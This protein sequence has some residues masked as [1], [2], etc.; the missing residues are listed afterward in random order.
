M[1]LL[2]YEMA[3]NSEIQSKLSKELWECYPTDELN[4][5]DMNKS[6]Y[7]DAVVNET[8]RKHTTVGRI[9]RKTLA[10]YDFGDF[11]VKKGQTIGIS[12]HNLHNDPALF[13]EPQ[14]FNPERFISGELANNNNFQPIPFVDGPSK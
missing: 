4:Y 10:D 3:I 5:E 7:L 1:S 8:L 14:K 11:K 13:K 12:L 9:F 6:K 2:L